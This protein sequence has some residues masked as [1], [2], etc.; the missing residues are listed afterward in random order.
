MPCEGS[1]LALV[2]RKTLRATRLNAAPRVS[3]RPSPLSR[4]SLRWT[5]LWF[6]VPAVAP[7]LPSTPAAKAAIQLASDKLITGLYR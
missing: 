4:N 5:L 6:V 2:E 3:S 1:G 7:P